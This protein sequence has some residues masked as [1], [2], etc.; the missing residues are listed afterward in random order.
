MQTGAQETNAVPIRRKSAGGESAFTMV[1]IALS[2]AVV[3]FAL[4]AIIGVLPL[5][6]TVQKDNREDT[7]ITQEGRYWL[8]AIK[9]GA[10]GLDHLTNYV[11]QIKIESTP[12]NP[13]PALVINNT[14]TPSLLTP[15]EIVGLLSLEKF[16]GPV[17]RRITNRITARVKT[18]TGPATEQSPVTNTVQSTFRYQLQAEI[19]PHYPLPPQFVG[20]MVAADT[21][22]TQTLV[23][24][25]AMATNLWE[26]RL[27]LRWPVVER[28][29][30]WWIGNNRKTFRARVSG[31]LLTFTNFNKT[32]IDRESLRRFAPNH[33][34]VAVIQPP[35]P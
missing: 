28:G 10:W 18:I 8:E 30:D 15:Q 17:D 12:S 23:F 3:A 22:N 27:V 19:T 5:G 25:E 1:E 32:L 2:L 4:V 11:E 34:N 21:N 33:F 35:Q 24:N 31:E 29:N 14:N 6:M 26:V 20:N 9:G 13:P 16:E 7:L